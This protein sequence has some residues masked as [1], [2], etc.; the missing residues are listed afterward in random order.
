MLTIGPDEIGVTKLTNGRGSITFATGPQIAT[1]ET[2]K[3]RRAARM[4]AFPL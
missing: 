4:R 2:T 1:G 3:H